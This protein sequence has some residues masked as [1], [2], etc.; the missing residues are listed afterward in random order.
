MEYISFKSKNDVVVYT[1][2]ELIINN[3]PVLANIL[4]LNN[5]YNDKPEMEN[6]SYLYLKPLHEESILF[7][8]KFLD[9]Y[10]SCN[11]DEIHEK[12]LELDDDQCN[13]EDVSIEPEIL[14]Y[15]KNMQYS[16]F[17]EACE[18]CD[19]LCIYIPKRYWLIAKKKP[20]TELEDIYNEYQFIE[21]ILDTSFS[22]DNDGMHKVL[23]EYY[24]SNNWEIV[25]QQLLSYQQRYGHEVYVSDIPR[26]YKLSLRRKIKC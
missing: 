24:I 23:N 6:G 11:L 26:T 4:N 15:I 25:N 3:A 12:N 20:K 22:S 18:F 21:I 19:P 17:Q 7:I 8:F 5:T 14:M 2:K 10:N 16:N 13:I 9:C 1:T